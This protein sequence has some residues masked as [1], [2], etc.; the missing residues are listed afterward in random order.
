MATAPGACVAAP[1]LIEDRRL[2]KVLDGRTAARF[3]RS[4]FVRV[5]PAKRRVGGVAGLVKRNG[6]LRSGPF[7][8]KRLHAEGS[9]NH[10]PSRR[11]TA[12]PARVR[13]E[14]RQ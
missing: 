2:R 4:P 9:M 13:F 7:F 6:R 10:H 11:R 14:M 1:D 8:F 3:A 5:F 12:A